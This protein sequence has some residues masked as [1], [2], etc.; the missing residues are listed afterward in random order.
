MDASYY[1]QMHS[2]AFPEKKDYLMPAVFRQYPRQIFTNKLAA[3][4]KSVNKK[5]DYFLLLEEIE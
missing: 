4:V 2:G 3:H 5:S 1:M